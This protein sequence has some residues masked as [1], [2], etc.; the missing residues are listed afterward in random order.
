[1][2]EPVYF[3]IKWRIISTLF[4]GFILFLMGFGGVLMERQNLFSDAIR[5]LEKA[6]S[7]TALK[8]RVKGVNTEEAVPV[9]SNQSGSELIFCYPA[10]M[11]RTFER[12]KT[13][14]MREYNNFSSII[15]HP[16]PNHQS[17]ESAIYQLSIDTPRSLT[18][19]FQPV[20]VERNQKVIVLKNYLYFRVPQAMVNTFRDEFIYTSMGEKPFTIHREW[21]VNGMVY[22]LTWEPTQNL[23]QSTLFMDLPEPV[24]RILTRL[25]RLVGAETSL[26]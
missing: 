4:F 18:L 10:T 2:N 1:M 21:S 6:G 25:N 9:W 22:E 17:W 16:I 20:Y 14:W 24:T 5:Y 12:L 11:W 7:Y 23:Y 3:K 15:F 8:E 26:F 13:R 19:G